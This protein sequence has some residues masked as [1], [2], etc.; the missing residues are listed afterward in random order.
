MIATKDDSASWG[1]TRRCVCRVR[2]SGPVGDLLADGGPAGR[3]F[4]SLRFSV[5]ARQI[6]HDQTRARA[7]NSSWQNGFQ[8]GRNVFQARPTRRNKP[9]P[10]FEFQRAESPTDNSPGQS[11]FASDALGSRSPKISKPCRGGTNPRACR[12]RFVPATLAAF[13]KTKRPENTFTKLI[14]RSFGCCPP[15][16]R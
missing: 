1:V 2:H 15:R 4:H 3:A 10:A 13:R 14:S 9:K 12:R 6:T 8:F 5:H 11:E 7:W 16:N